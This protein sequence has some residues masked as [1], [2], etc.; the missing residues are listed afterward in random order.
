MILL[1]LKWAF[2]TSKVNNFEYESEP[3][4]YVRSRKMPPV[5]TQTLASKAN[6]EGLYAVSTRTQGNNTKLEYETLINCLEWFESRGNPEA[7]NR[8]DPYTPSYSV[9]QFKRSTFEH[10][11]VEK[12]GYRNDIWNPEIQRQCANDMIKN[13]WNNIFHWSTA[14]Q[15]LD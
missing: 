1:G 3:K 7:F 14:Q 4:L 8:Y 9:L 6:I 5:E 2:T 12:Y 10:Y 13:D 15:C 11:C